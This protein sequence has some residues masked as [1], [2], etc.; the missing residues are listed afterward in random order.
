MCLSV[1]GKIIGSRESLI[2][3]IANIGSLLSM[4]SYMPT[5]SVRKFREK[6]YSGG[7]YTPLQML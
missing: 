4:G 2:T 1:L 7:E 3:V 6:Q 5:K